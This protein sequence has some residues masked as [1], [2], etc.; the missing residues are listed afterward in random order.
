MTE[1]SLQNLPVGWT[2]SALGRLIAT[3]TKITYGIVKPGVKD[4][5]GVL[6]VRGGDISDGNIQLDQ[7]R[8][9]S[10]QVSLS[11]PRTL[12]CGGELLMSL[13]GYPG[14]VAL[15]PI[16]L[17]GANIARQV[18]CIRLGNQV[19]S[20]YVMHYLR[21][22][23]GRHFL[24]QK[25]SGSAQQVIN[26]AD[27]KNVSITVAPLA[28]QIKIA[29]V[30]S[31]TD[32]LIHATT[33]KIDR[34]KHLKTGLIQE[35]LNK[36]IG[37][38][39]FQPSPMGI[40]PKAWEIT[41]LGKIVHSLQTGPFGAQLHAY[42]YLPSG[43][44]V[45]MPKDMKDQ[46]IDSAAI[47]HISPARASELERFQLQQGDILFSRRG[48]VARS[49]LV[50]EDNAGWI[51]GTGC[52]RARLS[53][54]LLPEFFI[55]YLMLPNVVEWLHNHAVGQTMPNLNRA[56]LSDLPVLVPSLAEQRMIANAMQ[57]INKMLRAKEA[58]LCQLQ[59]T[60]KSLMQ[61]L[62]TGKVRI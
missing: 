34:L 41:T 27:L 31:C 28:E 49:V 60:K 58:K 4:K 18:A 14:E 48:D 51:C 46:L 59:H 6:L 36:G 24:F 16:Q 62:L 9:V 57:S 42:E 32:N 61:D 2:R 37:H 35:L 15:V 1:Q 12:L 43:T 47:A 26:L 25:A 11:S 13:V 54:R 38:Q 53:E 21:S 7:L 17:A 40:I 8:T 5:R 39:T 19:D 33:A 23:L 45:V 56:I 55:Y 10:A 3:G 20:G 52:L 44:P 30:L 29:A 22:D 50:N